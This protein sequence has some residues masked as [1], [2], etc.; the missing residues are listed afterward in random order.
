MHGRKKETPEKG[1]SSKLI[2]LWEAGIC[3]EGGHTSLPAN[4]Y[5]TGCLAGAGGRGR[6]T[7]A[8]GN[9]MPVCQTCL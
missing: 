9:V 4:G 2:G 5:P 1:G 7:P 3:L 6:G 8:S